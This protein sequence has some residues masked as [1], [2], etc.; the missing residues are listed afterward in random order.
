MSST[1]A[2]VGSRLDRGQGRSFVALRP[3][4]AVVVMVAVAFIATG[5]TS[6][7]ESATV[8]VP[9]SKAA[10]ASIV[11]TP[12]GSGPGIGLGEAAA[13]F[14]RGNRPT[15]GPEETAVA[16]PSPSD[17]TTSVDDAGTSDPSGTDA[18]TSDVGTSDPGTLDTSAS[19]A[20]ADSRLADD[21]PT[22]VAVAD[23]VVLRGRF[24]KPFVDFG[25]ALSSAGSVDEARALFDEQVG[26]TVDAARA[27]L[28]DVS[29]GYAKLAV[30]QPQLIDALSTHLE[31]LSATL[32]AFSNLTGDDL[33][34]TQEAVKDRLGDL[35]NDGE[36]ASVKLDNFTQSACGVAFKTRA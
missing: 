33:E 31:F 35:A 26:D 1:Q 23:I 13:A 17:E 21:S 22:C 15:P 25:E 24:N 11:D 36:T 2:P 10:P 5:C 29:A 32:T 3:W 20:G 16:E 14:N 6:D 30:E 7:S 12:P 9:P 4:G 28:P 34:R 19:D 27:V 8:P 18:G